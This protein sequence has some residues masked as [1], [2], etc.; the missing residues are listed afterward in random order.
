MGNLPWKTILLGEKSGQTIR[1]R[2]SER[3]IGHSKNKQ[4]T[5]EPI[6]TLPRKVQESTI[7]QGVT[8]SFL[9]R[10]Y[11]RLLSRPPAVPLRIENWGRHP[12]NMATQN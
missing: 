8:L 10:F 4:L 12:T 11:W 3:P 5:Q 9:L 7:L 6:Q 1:L 2:P